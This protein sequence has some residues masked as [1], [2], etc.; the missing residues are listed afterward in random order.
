MA[1]ARPRG[2][3]VMV[4]CISLTLLACGGDDEGGGDKP[5]DP[6]AL[7]GPASVALQQGRAAQATLDVQD[8][9]GDAVTVA[10][11][12]PAG[13]EA[14]VS[15][16][17][18]LDAY[19][20]YT[21]TGSLPIAL[22]LTDAKGLTAEASLSADVAPIRW[23]ER[24]TWT[25]E[26]PPAREHAA[27][28][29]DEAG[30]RVV[31]IGGS[32]YAPQGTALGDIWQFDLVAKTWTAVTATG[33]VPPPAG[34]RRVAQVAGESIAYLQGGYGDNF[35]LFDDLYRVD[36]S[37]GGVAFT[38]L[39]QANPPPVRGLHGFSYDAQTDRFFVFAGIGASGPSS[40]PLGDLWTA[41]LDG[42]NATWTN[43][44]P[45]TAP[46]PRYGF[47]FGVDETNGRALLFS[48]ATLT[49]P[50]LDPARDIWALDMRAEP[51]AWS[52]L[53]EGEAAGVPPGRRNG[54]FVMDPLGP[55]L[56]IWGGTADA[57]S[58]EPGLFAFDARPGKEKW[59]QLTL[60]DEPPLRSSGNAIYD[61]INDRVW[62]G[63]GNDAATYRDFAS[64]G[65]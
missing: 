42:D 12:P 51:P 11:T 24:V 47:F 46:S 28:V 41:T 36:V 59:S 10:L 34:S 56:F 2:W 65:Y 14:T 17:L 61:P 15:A 26:G 63:F 6:P 58:T 60:A 1:M 44:N 7:V 40:A 25:T 54:C 8:P 13:I 18:V 50:T 55:R 33:D 39:T 32:G 37:G 45:A 31:V 49:G 43:V 16:D 62:L 9:N 64:L 19:A 35:A 30:K 20:D 22:T 29:M 57:A 3:V 23:V 4:S 53:L 52:L 48:G 5:N 27:L 21:A 38:K